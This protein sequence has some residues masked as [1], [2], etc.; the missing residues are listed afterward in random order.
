MPR[1]ILA[2]YEAALLVLAE[3]LDADYLTIQYQD[4]APKFDKLMA[5]VRNTVENS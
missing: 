5:K 3:V 4:A 2:K 1:T